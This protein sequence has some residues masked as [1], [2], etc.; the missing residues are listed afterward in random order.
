MIKAMLPSFLYIYL[1]IQLQETLPVKPIETQKH[2][3]Y[4][5]LLLLSLLL[6]QSQQV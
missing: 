4:I 1:S 6:V 5:D 3:F 2:H